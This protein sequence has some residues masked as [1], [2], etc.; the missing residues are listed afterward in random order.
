MKQ[1]YD[2]VHLKALATSLS[3][4]TFQIQMSNLADSKNSPQLQAYFSN[5]FPSLWSTAKAISRLDIIRAVN[6]QPE[7]E[8]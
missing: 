1:H 7:Q 8:L 4:A 3:F 5:T 6:I 2:Q